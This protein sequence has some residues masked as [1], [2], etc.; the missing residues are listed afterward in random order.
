VT[1]SWVNHFNCILSSFL[2]VRLYRSSDEYLAAHTSPAIPDTIQ[3]TG[4]SD[5]LTEAYDNNT[6]IPDD[7]S[8][9]SSL[10]IGS[11][12]SSVVLDEN[13]LLFPS[14]HHHY[15]YTTNSYSGEY[16]HFEY[17]DDPMLIRFLN[18]LLLA[19]RK[20]GFKTAFWQYFRLT[21]PIY[22]SAEDD[23]E[24][25]DDD[26]DYAEY[27]YV[28]AENE[29]EHYYTS[30]FG[31]HRHDTEDDDPHH[32]SAPPS[33]RHHMERSRSARMMSMTGSTA[34]RRDVEAILRKLAKQQKQQQLQPQPL[35]LQPP[36]A[37]SS[38]KTLQNPAAITGA[39]GSTSTST[40]S[41]PTTASSAGMSNRRKSKD[42]N[43]GVST[44]AAPPAVSPSI[45]NPMRVSNRLG[46]STR[47]AKSTR[48]RGNNTAR[49]GIDPNATVGSARISP[50]IS[51]STA[52]D[53]S[54]FNILEVIPPRSP[55]AS[56]YTNDM[57]SPFRD[58]YGVFM[59]R[60]I[61]GI[62]TALGTASLSTD[63]VATGANTDGSQ[64][65]P[66]VPLQGSETGRTSRSVES[67][68]S[69][70][71]TDRAQHENDDN[72]DDGKDDV[73]IY[74]GHKRR[75]CRIDMTRDDDSDG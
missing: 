51:P 31:R 70:M 67:A 22:L 68:D 75:V 29:D 21:Y 48:M 63:S 42:G 2:D 15:K 8:A 35:L 6:D 39:S 16:Y 55:G 5:S 4:Y 45:N 1:C 52:P 27:D 9:T 74:V 19:G 60:Q 69:G 36:Q 12:A 56:G 18:D 41:T 65:V 13:T 40:A 50:L 64:I 38:V 14:I 10:G 53:Q 34:A 59:D 33:A 71:M 46:A 23:E 28:D 25:E 58:D 62:A 17:E 54:M 26:D 30:L 72:R 49:T 66:P 43:I 3:A 47:A 37:A 57:D 61:T 11:S 24:Y 7:A 32:D 44:K 20:N 73:N